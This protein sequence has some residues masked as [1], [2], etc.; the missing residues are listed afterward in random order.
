MGRNQKK[1][2]NNQSSSNQPNSFANKYVPKNKQ[3]QK[4]NKDRR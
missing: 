4:D 2:T 3:L 1:I